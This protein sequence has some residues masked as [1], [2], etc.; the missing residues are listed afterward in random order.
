M[1]DL[2]SGRESEFTFNLSFSHLA[3]HRR[4]VM[5][6]NPCLSSIEILKLSSKIVLPKVSFLWSQ[7]GLYGYGSGHVGLQVSAQD[8]SSLLDMIQERG[9]QFQGSL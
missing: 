1:I 7:G 8:L 4:V 3:I 5:K 9:I 6:I 2:Q